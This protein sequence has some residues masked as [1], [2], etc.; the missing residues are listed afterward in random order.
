MPGVARV[1]DTVAGVCP[2]HLAPIAYTG[3]WASGSGTA[4]A[5]G[6]AVIRLGDTGPASCGHTFHAIAASSVVSNAGVPVHRLGD[7]VEI[8]GGGPGTTT[9]ASTDVTAA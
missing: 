2:Q 5:D 4:K 6:K 7:A 3:V 9:S 8:I 1:G